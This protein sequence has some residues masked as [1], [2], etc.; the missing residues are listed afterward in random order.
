MV[1]SIST[2]RT[3]LPDWIPFDVAP[4][5]P[6]SCVQHGWSCEKPPLSPVRLLC[7]GGNEIS[8]NQLHLQDPVCFWL[9]EWVVCRPPSGSEELHRRDGVVSHLQGVWIKCVS[10]QGDRGSEDLKAENRVPV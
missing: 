2:T 9:W 6:L 8:N 4:F 1:H 5:P 3:F 7:P 10:G